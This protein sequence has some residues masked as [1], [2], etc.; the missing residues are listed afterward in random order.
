MT[1]ELICQEFYRRLHR[2]GLYGMWWTPNGGSARNKNYS[3]YVSTKERF[4][5]PAAWLDRHL[6]FGIN[7]TIIR[8]EYYQ[9]ARMPD[10]VHTNTFFGD[11]DG[12]VV[13]VPPKDEV[14]ALFLELRNNPSR[15]N[16]PNDLLWREADLNVRKR[17]FALDRPF[18]KGQLLDRIL[19]LSVLPS[20]LV[21]SGGGYQ[22]YWLLNETFDFT[23]ESA[24]SFYKSVQ[25]RWVLNDPLADPLF[26]IRRVFR[27]PLADGDTYLTRNTKPAYGP[28]Y[29]AVQFVWANLDHTYDMNVLEAMLPEAEP[30]TPVERRIHK[31]YEGENPEDASVIDLYNSQVNIRDELADWSYTAV[32]RR[33]S[34]PDAEHSAGVRIHDGDNVS[35]HFST[36]D[37]LYSEHAWTPFGVLCKLGYRDNVK[38]AVYAAAERLGISHKQ[39]KLK[40]EENATSDQ[41]TKSVLDYLMAA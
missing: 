9:A 1:I 7:P 39:R 31:R 30:V 33:M 35:V 3:A 8:R 2:H 22:A 40:I 19:D 27:A 10:I 37:P 15:F 34:R 20:A 32:H 41:K 14:L 4:M 16:H 17:H 25:K 6:Y 28:D 13:V 36:M 23:E 26:D 38:A 5:P 11:Y 29:P 12:P 24:R 18:Y 21:D